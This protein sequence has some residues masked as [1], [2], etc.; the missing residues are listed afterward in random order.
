MAVEHIQ[1]VFF[2]ISLIFIIWE[3][4]KIKGISDSQ[5]KRNL[6]LSL[7]FLLIGVLVRIVNLDYM[8]GVNPD[9]AMAGYESW[10]LANYG[11]D[12]HMVSYPVYMKV[13]G[14]GMSALYIYWLCPL[15]KYS[16]CRKKCF[17]CRCPS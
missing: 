2:V 13:W 15:S 11:V 8:A 17:A 10:C 1:I 9:E 12:S 16:G 6:Y 3:I 4:F 14:S 5:D 7:L